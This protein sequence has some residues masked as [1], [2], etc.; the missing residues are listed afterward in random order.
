MEMEMSQ[1]QFLQFLFVSLSLA[2]IKG[3]SLYVVGSAIIYSGS[4]QGDCN[5]S[6][7]NWL[8]SIPAREISRKRHPLQR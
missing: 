4:T 1:S 2:L 6:W 7:P 8:H 3:I 5:C